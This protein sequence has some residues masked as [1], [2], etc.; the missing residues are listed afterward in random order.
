MA[1]NLLL[2]AAVLS[3]VFLLGEPKS[4]NNNSISEL[5]KAKIKVAKLES[6]LEENVRNLD[7]RNL[8]LEQQEKLIEDMDTKIRDLRS[9]L[10]GIKDDS[11]YAEESLIALKEEVRLLWAASRK[12]NFDL[13]VLKLQAKD[14][15]A[16]V[17]LATSQ[18]EKMN[19]IVTEQWIQIQQLEQALHITEMRTLNARKQVSSRRCSFLKFIYHVS[20]NH[21]SEVFGAVDF[22][23][24]GK[25]P[26]WETY[27]SEAVHHFEQFY[28]T[29]KKYHH[30]LQR[31]VKQEMERHDSTATLANAELVF[32]LASALITFPVFGAWLFLLSRLS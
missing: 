32:F 31:L 8:Y 27:L 3:S 26:I 11:L 6:A 17:E 14:T 13:H 2:L 9:S 1:I 18:V 15:A 22:H 21:L 5:R 23:S 29:V 30:E 28:L 20:E 12:N 7:A 24:T 16:E 19:D 10:L 25:R 4:A